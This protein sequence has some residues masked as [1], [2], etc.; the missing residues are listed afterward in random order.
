MA[1]ARLA[2]LLGIVVLGCATYWQA[3]TAGTSG[4]IA[5]HVTEAKSESIH[6]EDRYAYSFVLVLQETQGTPITFTTMT[7]TVYSG[8]TTHSPSYEE[9]I[10]RNIPLR[11]RS[12]YRLPF[13]FTITCPELKGCSPI[14]ALAPTYHI[15]LTGTD[16]HAKPVQVSIDI[17]L[18]PDP[19]AIQQ[20]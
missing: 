2:L 19:K 18:P 6:A 12:A 14:I 13:T 17:K 11:P 4:P 8:T 1:C 7:Y 16:N 20:R 15:R 3:H 9:T 10:H 5:W